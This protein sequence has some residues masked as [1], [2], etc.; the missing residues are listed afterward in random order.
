METTAIIA[1]LLNIFESSDARQ[2]EKVQQSFA[3][4][5]I[6]DY[7][8]LAGG[9]PVTLTPQQI[10]NAWQQVLPGFY[11]THHQVGSFTAE[12]QGDSATA[13]CHGLAL[14]Y[15][16][17]DTHNNIWVV[18]GTY[19]FSLRRQHGAWKVSAMRLNLQKQAGNLQLPALAQEQVKAG[20]P[21]PPATLTANARAAVESY[22]S[23][24]EKMDINAFM[25]VW[26]ED[27]RQEMPLSPAGFPSLLP[28]RQAIHQQYKAL[29]ENYSSMRFP[30]KLFATDRPDVV[31]AQFSGNI[32]LKNGGAYNNNYVNIFRVEGNRI[33]TVTEY[34]DPFI[35]EAAFGSTLQRSFNVN[36]AAADQ[37]SRRDIAF[38]SNGLVLKG[39]LYLPPG[40][41]GHRQYPAVIVAG[42]W[43]TVKEQ[44]P[45]LY[46]RQLAAQG[47]IALTFDFRYFGASEG[48]P[49]EFENPRAKI[50][51][52][53]EAV[54]WLHAQ[55]FTDKDR[56]ALAGICASAGYMAD[57]AT[58][59]PRV[60]A[61]VAIAPWLHN[62]ALLE[63]IY[64][65]RPGGVAGLIAG[66]EAAAHE[67]A[68]SG[69]TLTIPAASNTDSSAAMYWPGD[70][71]DYYLNPA[72]GAIPE[73]PNRLAVLSWPEWLG[74]DG[75][76]IAR[77]VKQPV[78]IIHSENAAIPDGA[79]QFYAQLPASKEITW[80]NQYNQF[81]FYYQ[82]AAVAQ[83]TGLVVK[84]LEENM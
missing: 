23:A 25:E 47:Y 31:I 19:D 57:A 10:T 11:S 70:T 52:I 27:A 18:T 39:H 64:G 78:Y 68:A 42:S 45:A 71:L 72:K 32:Q 15:L 7:T 50:A 54:S 79:R 69:K 75:V 1:V 13:T 66:G 41:S 16:P 34:F 35:L 36:G 37:V 8:S 21:W 40:F 38:T 49:R 55:P 63:G 51:D 61:V 22:F 82:P 56:I 44:M 48:Q 76:A 33:K 5:V 20:R 62:A 26:S 28:D 30:R 53:Q 59:D 29:P 46:A 84:W 9:E 24:L 3:Q 81:D 60:K 83:T 43:I 2:W 80:L 6:L 67:F 14:H 17:N 58:A 12:V 65:S 74:F 4:E 73:W 77:Q